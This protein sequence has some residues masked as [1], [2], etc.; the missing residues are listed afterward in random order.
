MPQNS[1]SDYR[2]VVVYWTVFDPLCWPQ[3]FLLHDI[4]II[5]LCAKLSHGIHVVMEYPTCNKYQYMYLFAIHTSLKAHVYTKKIQVTCG[6]FH[7][8]LLKTI[9]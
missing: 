8:I 9:A 3:H 4:K 2:K 1:Q 6:I 7:G 5:V